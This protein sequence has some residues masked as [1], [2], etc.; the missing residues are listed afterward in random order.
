M[1]RICFLGDSILEHGYFIYALRSYIYHEGI[2]AEIYNRGIGGMSSS[3]V[4]DEQLEY[5]VFSLNPDYCVVSYGINDLGIWLYDSSIEEKPEVLEEREKHNQK[6]FNG[7]KEIVKKL[8]EKGVIPVL[9]SPYPVNELLEEKDGIETIGDNKEKAELIG[10]NFYRNKTMSKINA[11]LRLYNCWLK[12]YVEKEKLL[13]LDIFER[14][15]D[16]GLEEEGLFNADG[17]HYTKKGG[18]YIARSIIE[19]HQKKEMEFVFK[20]SKANDKIFTFERKERAYAFMKLNYFKGEKF[21]GYTD[22]QKN[23]HLQ[24]EILSNEEI[25]SWRKDYAKAY[26]EVGGEEDVLRE[27]LIALTQNYIK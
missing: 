8:K 1:K 2:Q 27:R 19:T 6:Y 9:M 7:I 17:I 5:E 26:L 20:S 25:A 18:E 13:F 15:R 24:Q 22:E 23:E 14:L 3:I 4:S 12:K 11:S 10:V 16:Y 21:I